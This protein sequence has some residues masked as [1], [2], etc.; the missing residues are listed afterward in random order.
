[1][2]R[3]IEEN[4]QEYLAEIKKRKS[5]EYKDIYRTVD[6]ILEDVRIN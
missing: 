4:I 6:E 1:M 3:I 2:V 5:E